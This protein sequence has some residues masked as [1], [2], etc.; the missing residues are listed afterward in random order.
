MIF[1]LQTHV[2]IEKEIPYPKHVPIQKQMKIHI[3]RH[4]PIIIEKPLKYTERKYLPISDDKVDYRRSNI[5]NNEQ[6]VEGASDLSAGYS[7]NQTN[8]T[9]K[10]TEQN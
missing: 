4:V 7:T 3:E 8:G 5:E 1:S 9:N 10:Q 2:P 6:R